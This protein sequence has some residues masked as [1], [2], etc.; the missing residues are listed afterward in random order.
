MYICVSMCV[1]ERLWIKQAT[2][3]PI[4]HHLSSILFM[5]WLSLNSPPQKRNNFCWFDGGMQCSHEL[6]ALVQ[7]RQFWTNLGKV[8]RWP[9]SCTWWQTI[10]YL[11]NQGDLFLEMLI[12]FYKFQRALLPHHTLH[13]PQS[14]YKSR[15]L[16]RGAHW[17]VLQDC[18]Q[19]FNFLLNF[20]W[21]SPTICSE[22]NSWE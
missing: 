20:Q 8:C 18:S 6:W 4:L 15:M 11:E 16:H 3:P 2:A 21:Y 13:W 1:S 22:M 5:T 9:H 17:S 19:L 14:I 7:V 12:H 10:C